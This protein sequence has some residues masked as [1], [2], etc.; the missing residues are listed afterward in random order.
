MFDV[1]N[2]PAELLL[3]SGARLCA[4]NLFLAAGGPTF[5]STGLLRNNAGS[6]TIARLIEISVTAVQQNLVLGPTL[7]SAATTGTRAFVDGRVFGEGTTL[8]TMG[9]NNN[10][11]IGSFFYAVNTGAD[12]TVIYRPPVAISVISPG[13]AFSVGCA[14]VDTALNLSFLWIERQAQPSELNL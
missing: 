4:A 3:L 10:L 1:E 5:F 6:G 8:I 11:V 7:N 14:A 13:T 9:S 2:V 12:G